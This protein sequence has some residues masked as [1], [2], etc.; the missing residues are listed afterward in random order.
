LPAP[1]LQGLAKQAGIT[2]AKAE[3]YW[4]KAKKL[5]KDQGHED[6]Y[7]YIVGIVKKM[8]G[9]TKESHVCEILDSIARIKR[10]DFTY[11]DDSGNVKI[12]TFQS[13]V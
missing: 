2:L 6:D 11:I 8:M 1:V 4:D 7:A 9:L 3:E 5:A 13:P 12:K 10:I